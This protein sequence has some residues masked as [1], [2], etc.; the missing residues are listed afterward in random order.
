MKVI[1]EIGINH[2]GDPG[3]AKEMISVAAESGADAVKFQTFNCEVL[4]PPGQRR[5]MLAKYQLSD[6]AFSDLSSECKRVGVEFMSTPF[7]VVS[8]WFLVNDLGMQTVKIASGFLRWTNFLHAAEQCRK[9]V[10][11]STGGA[12]GQEIS[13][14]LRTLKYAQDITL[15]HCVSSYPAPLEESNLLAIPAMIWT[16]GC[17]V[18]LSDHSNGILAP[19][20]A[21]SIGASVIEKHFTLDRSMPGPDH[22]A[23]L[24]PDEFKDMA[25]TV[26][27]LVPTMLG[28]GDKRPQPSEEAAMKIMKERRAWADKTLRNGP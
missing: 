10:I 1:A 4:E 2:N 26:K 16:Y 5:D 12:T 19:I 22:K 20:V 21:A 18:G 7:D 15:L 25:F 17:E 23:S 13:S 9:P 6:T 8:L 11:L 28:D 14:A 3:L 24:Q 27:E